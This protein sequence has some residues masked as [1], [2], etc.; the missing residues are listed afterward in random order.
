MTGVF[1][2]LDL[3]TPGWGEPFKVEFMVYGSRIAIR[4]VYAFIEEFQVYNNI[5]V[6]ILPQE[7]E[8]AKFIEKIE[9][10]LNSEHFT[11]LKNEARKRRLESYGPDGGP[12][13][14]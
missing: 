4:K 5:T 9:D 2:S 13:A 1:H 10:W 11:E 3:D 6:D 7:K 12:D 8:M 14:A